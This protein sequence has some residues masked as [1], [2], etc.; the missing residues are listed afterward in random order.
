MQS[1]VIYKWGLLD[2]IITIRSFK[3]QRL[4]CWRVDLLFSPN[5]GQKSGTGSW[6]W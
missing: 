6:G 1:V 5:H 2:G 3:L 4:T